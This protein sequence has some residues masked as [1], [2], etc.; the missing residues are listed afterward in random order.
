MKRLKL[1]HHVLQLQR[2]V[3]ER[4]ILLV[5]PPHR[6]DVLLEQHLLLS[7]RLNLK[8]QRA[9]CFVFLTL[10][11]RVEMRQGSS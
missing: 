11:L 2:P 3:G 5:Q 6:A 10:G 8:A 9:H 7:L 4:R 1:L